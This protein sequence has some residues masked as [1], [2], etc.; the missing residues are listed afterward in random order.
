VRLPDGSVR[1]RVRVLIDDQ[2]VATLVVD[3]SGRLQRR[4]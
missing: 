4:R 2:R 3:Q 1:H